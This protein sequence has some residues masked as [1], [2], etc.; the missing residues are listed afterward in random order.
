MPQRYHGLRGHKLNRAVAAIAGIGFLLFGYDQGVMGGLLTLPEF[1]ETFPAMSTS[2]SLPADVRAHN[3]TIQGTA[4]A[5]YEIGCMMGAITT[6][7]LGDKLGRRKM[8]FIGA[9]IMIA[10]AAIQCSSFSLAQFIV[11]RVITGYGN[12]YITAT[13][14]MWQSECAKAEARGKLVMIQGALITG[15]I[16]ISYWV[17][18]GFYFVDNQV[19]WRFP[20]AFQCVFA[21]ILVCTVLQLPESPRWLIRHGNEQEA[22]SVFSALADIDINHPVI[23]EQVR[24]IKATISAEHQGR[25]RDIFTFKREKHF[26]RA[27]LAFWNQAMQQVTGINLITYYAAT[28]YENSIGLSPLNSKIL[29]AANGTEYFIASWIAFFTIERIGRRKL[30]L[31]GAVGQ[32]AT[33]AVLTGTAH[34]ADNGNT[35]A[36]IAAATFL[37]VFNTFFAI[38]W[39]GMTWLYPAEIVSLQIRAPANGLSTAANWIFNF[40]VVMI[41]PVAFN[42]IGAYTYLVFAVINAIMVPCVYFFY[43]ETAGR[44]LEEIDEIFEKSNPWTPWDVVGIAA[45]LPRHH[46]DVLE[47]ADEENDMEAGAR[48]RHAGWQQE[49]EEGEKPAA[50]HSDQG[51]SGTTDKA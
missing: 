8:I 7:W 33:M 20:V 17:D 27:M 11:A 41:T 36:G 18:F 26:H 2:S 3:S 5:L 25:I 24:E 51:S 10:G 1:I 42:N 44:S 43:P 32:A 28:I 14:P 49:D 9:C 39:L 23:D 38:G 31:F 45:R 46:V 48:R 34:A 13:V 15:G 16:A 4:V 30:M 50:S 19:N 47:I 21:I 12:G 29:A 37:F 6:M 22:K 35:S 40:M